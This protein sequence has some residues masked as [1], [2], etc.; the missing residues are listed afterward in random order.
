[1]YGKKKPVQKMKSGKLPMVKGKDGKMIPKFAA[2]GKG[3]ND[4]LKK[5]YGGAMKPV[6]KMAEGTR[7]RRPAPIE[8][9]I[10]KDILI[11]AMEEDRRI[12]EANEKKPVEKKRSGGICRGMGAATKGGNYKAS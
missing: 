10:S 8:E 1:M 9:P 7:T 6:K 12:E 4:T 3:A 11:Q 2:D 5:K